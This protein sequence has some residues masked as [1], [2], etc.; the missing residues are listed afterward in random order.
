MS[1]T[2]RTPLAGRRFADEVASLVLNGYTADIEASLAALSAQRQALFNERRNATIHEI[3]EIIKMK[4]EEVVVYFAELAAAEEAASTISTPAMTTATTATGTTKRSAL[5][6]PPIPSSL[7]SR[8]GASNKRSRSGEK[9]KVMFNLGEKIPLVSP[10]SDL[11]LPTEVVVADSNADAQYFKLPAH[12]AKLDLDDEFVG[13]SV[14]GSGRFVSGRSEAAA[15]ETLAFET[16]PTLYRHV[17]DSMV[18]TI[19]ENEKSGPLKFT[20]T[21]ARPAGD[22]D[23]D[24]VMF[25]LDETLSP[26]GSPPST[27]SFV[28]P[29]SFRFQ[30]GRSQS[31]TDYNPSAWK[32]EAKAATQSGWTG[33]QASFQTSATNR[34]GSSGSLNMALAGATNESDE[35]PASTP[36]VNI[37]GPSKPISTVPV[38][39][40]EDSAAADVVSL[41]TYGSSAPIEIDVPSAPLGRFGSRSLH[42]NSGEMG[43][44]GGML[45]EDEEYQL[46][47]MRSLEN[48]NN[49]SF[50][51]RIIWEDKIGFHQSR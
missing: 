14:L 2:A 4:I 23:G 43:L 40:K 31:F 26:R 12:M 34:V 44:P 29:P 50:S 49:L 28:K 6:P 10:A 47:K 25:H 13:T 20:T 15:S 1:T 17:S 32:T 11:M 46:L 37:G 30:V 39:P 27:S 45:G 42:D 21:G 8:D 19:S 36:A 5:T 38:V 48:P 22:D 18:V 24:D 7:R 16:Y 41:S 3:K 35:V 51:H 33:N 9:K